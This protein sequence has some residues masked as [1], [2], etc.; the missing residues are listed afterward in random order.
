[1]GTE[2]IVDLLKVPQR[3]NAGAGASNRF[4]Y[5]HVWAFDYM[6]KTLDSSKDFM[7][8]MEFHDD[9]IILEDACDGEHLDFYQIK[10][11]DKASRYITSS[12]IIKDAKKYPDKMSIAQKMII[13]YIKFK[14]NINSIHLV[15]NKSFDLGTLENTDKSTSRYTISLKEIMQKELNKIKSGM[16]QA[17]DK[18]ICENKCLD[19]I[20]FDVSDLALDSYEDTVM[21]RMVKK[22][23]LLGI[24]STLER[25]RSIYNTILGEIRRI[26]NTEKLAQNVDEL[27]QRKSITKADFMKWISH[28]KIVIP[29]DLWI[30]IQSSL[31]SDGFT[32]LELRKIQK[33]WKKYRIESMNVDSSGLQK[34]VDYARAIILRDEDKYYNIKKLIEHVYDEIK[35]KSEAAI[36]SKNYIYALIIKELYS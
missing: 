28:L 33:E 21:G 34:M 12:F 8:F 4:T 13:D 30:E 3:E 5:Q 17:C 31:I 11:D 9:I 18:S 26:N 14:D 2:L 7:L 16:C 22:M 36:Y 23:D 25:T 32:A 1:M 19:L 10:T 15:S 24:P 35:T 6:I 27:L 20:Y 29:D